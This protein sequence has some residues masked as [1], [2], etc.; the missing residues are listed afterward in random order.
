MANAAGL[1]IDL[2]VIGR[3][4]AWV[5]FERLK[6]LVCGLCRSCLDRRFDLLFSRIS[7]VDP[8]AGAAIVLR[9]GCGAIRRCAAVK[10]PSD[11]AQNTGLRMTVDIFEMLVGRV[12]HRD[13]M[14]EREIGELVHVSHESHENLQMSGVRLTPMLKSG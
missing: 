13:L 6:R 4:R 2:D 11:S 12:K 3:E 8:R 14:I 9:P 7:G 10:Q 5:V 1:D